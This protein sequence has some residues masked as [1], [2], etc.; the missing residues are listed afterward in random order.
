[1]DKKK[2]NRHPAGTGMT[3]VEEVFGSNHI[4]PRKNYNIK[5]PK[6]QVVTTI[7]F[8]ILLS[9]IT[10]WVVLDVRAQ[11]STEF[12]PVEHKVSDGDTLWSIAKQYKPDY[13]TMDEYMAWVYDHNDDGMIYAGDVVTMAEVTR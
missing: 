8:G 6:M 2:E 4:K 11:Q 9:I 1:M 5:P 7:L 10:V 3:V 13:M 12:T